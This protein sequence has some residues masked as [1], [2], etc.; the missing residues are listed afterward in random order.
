MIACISKQYLREKLSV[1]SSRPISTPTFTAL[2]RFHHLHAIVGLD[3][4]TF[5]N[6]KVFCKLQSDAL[7]EF[8][9]LDKEELEKES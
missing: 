6:K 5:K 1:D 8:F 3:E 4:R 9:K 2:C 7:L